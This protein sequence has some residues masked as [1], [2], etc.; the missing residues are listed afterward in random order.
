VEYLKYFRIRCDLGSFGDPGGPLAVVIVVLAASLLCALS[1]NAVDFS[2][3]VT[4][5]QLGPSLCGLRVHLAGQSRDYFAAGTQSGV[6]SLNSFES[7]SGGFTVQQVLFPG[8]EVRAI[9]PW[10]GRPG[11][12]A[13]LVVAA[14]NPDQLF[15]LDVQPVY[16]FLTVVAEVG[17]PEDPGDL[18]FMGLDLATLA[19]ALPGVDRVVLVGQSTGSWAIEAEIATGDNPSS[20]VGVDLEGD[21]IVELVLAQTGPLSHTLGIVRRQAGGTYSLDTV[22]LPGV[23]PGLVAAGDLDGD[24][25]MELAVA[26]ADTTEIVFYQQT[27]GGLVEWD[28]AHSS[29]V[30]SSLHLG[31]LADGT[32]TLYVASE[33]RGVVEFAGLRSGQWVRWGIYYPGCQPHDTTLADIDGDGLD[34]LIAMGGA[35]AI[36]TTMLGEPA[37]GYLGFPA[38]GLHGLPGAFFS[39][40]MDGDGLADLVVAAANE[41]A[42][43]FFRATSSGAL[44][45]TAEYLELG[46]VPNAILAAD[47]DADPALELIALDFVR[48]EVVVLDFVAPSQLLEVSRTAVRSFPFAVSAGDLD[49]DGAMDLLVLTQGLPEVNPVFGVGD[50]TLV[51]AVGFGF[52]LAADR[53]VP[54]D[55]NAD[56]LLDVV[57]TDGRS[58]VWTR[59]NSGGRTFGAEAF[60]AAGA[61]A[62][63]L[64][65]GDLDNDQD[66]DLVVANRT[67]Q[68]LS[69][70]ENDGSGG[71]V[72]RVDAL[73]L[74]GAPETVVLADFS[75]DGRLDVLL[76][77]PVASELNLTIGIVDWTYSLPLV[78]LGGPQMSGLGVIDADLNSVP[79]ILVID[80]ALQLGLVLLNRDPALVAVAPLAVVTECVGGEVR[81]RIR[82]NRPGPWELSLGE[83]GRWTEV[84]RNGQ[85]IV[86][87]VEFDGGTWLW[88]MATEAVVSRMGRPAQ[89]RLTIGGAGDRE[90]RVWLLAEDC[91][92]GVTELP[93]VVVWT[94]DPW[95]NPFNP[96]VETSFL[97]RR[98]TRVDADVVDMAGHRVAWLVQR[99]LDPGE[100]VL[101]WNG[102]TGRGTAAAGVYFLRIRTAVGATARKIVLVK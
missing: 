94:S 23:S 98:R 9:I 76:N 59:L 63:A 78:I 79:D 81:V 3:P 33:S 57:A 16:P 77:V 46:F 8:G 13:G 38:V 95:P 18:A 66:D 44:S 42:L 97:L 82:P 21:G 47:M 100:H 50:G 96:Q 26:C 69:I 36:L 1:A 28:R 102:V 86:G 22:V 15:F 10:S 25:L 89:V 70:F 40:D 49:A 45:M 85:A 7:Y 68:T 51:G 52:G 72:R 32:P 37:P 65:T 71:L 53:V 24:G 67:D 17:L 60:F 75:G 84:V 12:S 61:G 58:K 6:L 20:A 4:L 30:A 88:H 73:A 55:L 93:E 5:T 91:D 43:S 92:Q 48:S 34:D 35:G 74:S 56:G 87:A 27:A 62:L 31:R 41:T 39:A 99:E 64:A 11:S 54:L 90:Q 2:G 14:A 19:V 29:I 101:R 80:Q 83:P